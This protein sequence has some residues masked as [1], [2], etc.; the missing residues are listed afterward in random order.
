MIERAKTLN[1]TIWDKSYLADC[2][3]H[4]EIPFAELETRMQEARLEI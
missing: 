3:A 1:V 4:M 2:L